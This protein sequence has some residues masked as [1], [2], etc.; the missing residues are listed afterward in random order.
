VILANF[1]FLPTDAMIVF[2]ASGLSAVPIE[3]AIGARQRGLTVIAVT[4]VAQSMA[5]EPRHEA[6]RLL[7]NADIV[8]DLGTPAGD[9][10]VQ[11]GGL[12]TPVAPGST[13]AAV[14]IANEI[15][16]RTARTLAAQGTLP[17][18]I[19]S[20]ARVGA[21]RSAELFDAAYAEH[22]RRAAHA[23]RTR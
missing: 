5:A 6:G 2:S 14:A 17:P 13:V 22:A 1:D 23:L 7:D 4:S 16:A 15:K 19:T 21:K 10:L 20:P 3:M 18:V 8:L 9:A 12:D 11:I